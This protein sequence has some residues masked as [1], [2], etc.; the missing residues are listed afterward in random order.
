MPCWGSAR[1]SEHGSGSLEKL[2]RVPNGILTRSSEIRQRERC[3][4]RGEVGVSVDR[5]GNKGDGHA[6]VVCPLGDL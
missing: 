5:S 1:S 2:R 6:V 3:V 4:E